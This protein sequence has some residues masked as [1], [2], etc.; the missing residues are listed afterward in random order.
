MV[1]M[2]SLLQVTCCSL[3]SSASGAGAH[4]IHV[5]RR[6]CE[7]QLGNN[8]KKERLIK[9]CSWERTLPGPQVSS[10]HTDTF[11]LSLLCA[12]CRERRNGGDD[13][14]WEGFRVPPVT[15]RT[16]LKNV[17]DIGRWWWV[18]I[19]QGHILR[20]WREEWVTGGR[21]WTA[22][23]MKNAHDETSFVVDLQGWIY[24]C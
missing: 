8:N 10:A 2:L 4:A 20:H 11:L 7:L 1:A 6:G 15:R 19:C 24:A 18:H 22:L 5:V 23:M 21:E 17:V 9:K 13:C 14:Q 3:A 16:M 12:G